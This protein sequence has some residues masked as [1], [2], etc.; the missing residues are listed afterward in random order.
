MQR[1]L[2]ISTGLAP[3]VVTEMLW[4]YVSG[5][6]APGVPPDRIIVVTTRAG[7]DAAHSR[8]LGSRG[9][10]SEFCREFCLPNLDERVELRF[11]TQDDLGLGDDI[12]DVEANIG[13]ANLI[14][15]LLLELTT[16]PSTQVHASLAGGRKTMSFYM[17]YAMSLLGRE[18]DELSHVLVSPPTLENSAD[19]W[20]K[21]AC[22]RM[23]RTGRNGQMLS[24]DEVSIDVATIPFV[25]L[26]HLM[27][28]AL[29]AGPAVDF[30][31][32][33]VVAQSGLRNRRVVLTDSRLEV[34]VGSH[35]ATLAPKKY[36]LYR[37]LAECRMGG[38]R[39]AGIKGI[40]VNPEGWLSLRDV[41]EPNAAP[42]QRL[43]Q[44][45]EDL[46]Q[47]RVATGNRN[48]REIYGGMLPDELRTEFN[49]EI[50]NT[51]RMLNVRFNHYI[52]RDRVR[53]RRIAGNPK[54]GVPAR[55]GLAFDSNEIEI[56]AD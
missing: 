20:W 55:F 35:A 6:D 36:A 29:F 47:S 27:E 8:L 34:R 26:R 30:A 28:P 5:S 19:F 50:A 52:A 21:P 13:Y 31:R 45:Y 23:V 38:I 51:N 3:Q 49:R 54:S 25:R 39:R 4:W 42:V 15:R 40:G 33:V 16:D 2:L 17:G 43:L 1:I 56:V 10:L 22:L 11:P 18:H 44:I 46:P 14:V 48:L 32:F 37:L 53:I 24:T 7:A 12:R 41:E 9:K